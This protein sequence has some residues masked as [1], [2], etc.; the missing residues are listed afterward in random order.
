MRVAISFYNDVL[1]GQVFN[2]RFFAVRTFEDLF[3]SDAS[4]RESNK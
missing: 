2:E 1:G 4:R 3:A